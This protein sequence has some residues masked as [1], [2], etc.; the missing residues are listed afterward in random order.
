[1]IYL[2]ELNGSKVFNS[3]VGDAKFIK[4]L[5]KNVF[6]NDV[7]K[8]ATFDTLSKQKMAFIKGKNK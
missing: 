2:K 1:M 8:M 6:S 5:M 4:V 7:I 3:M